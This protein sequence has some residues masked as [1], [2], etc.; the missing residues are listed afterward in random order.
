MPFLG[1][2]PYSSPPKRISRSPGDTA[3]LIMKISTDKNPARKQEYA[4]PGCYELNS[5][6]VL[7]FTY[8]GKRYSV[9]T[10]PIYTDSFIR[11]RGLNWTARAIFI[12]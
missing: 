6:A 2:E 12:N 4:S 8:E 11:E 7:K 10:G 3:T 9:Y 1:K 5:G